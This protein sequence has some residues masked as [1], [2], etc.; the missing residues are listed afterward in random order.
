[1]GLL[2]V[3]LLHGISIPITTLNS[4]SNTGSIMSEENVVLLEKQR[5][6]YNMSS[7]DE[8]KNKC[9]HTGRTS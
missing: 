1:M 8:E 3:G 7:K 9:L 2:V 5:A 4:S 6:M